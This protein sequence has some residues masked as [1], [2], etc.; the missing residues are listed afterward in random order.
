[1]SR[2]TIQ[3][4]IDPGKL[5]EN[6]KRRNER[7]G[8]MIYYDREKHNESVANMRRYKHDLYLKGELVDK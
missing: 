1:M 5:I 6:I 8:S 4:I 3:F 7:G 2:R